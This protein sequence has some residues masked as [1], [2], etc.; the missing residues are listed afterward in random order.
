MTQQEYLEEIS[1]IDSTTGG[2]SP[3]QLPEE[4][5][6]DLVQEDPFL[7]EIRVITNIQ[8]EYQ[9]IALAVGSRNLIRGIENTAPTSGDL[10]NAKISYRSLI[11]KEAILPYNV[12]F[13]WIKQNLAGNRGEQQLNEEFKKSFK[14]DLVDLAFNGDRAATDANPYYK[15]ITIADGYFRL[16]SNDPDVNFFNRENNDT[17]WKNSVFPSMVQLLQK[18]IRFN[19]QDLFFL[20]SPEVAN[21]YTLQLAD[22]GTA[23]GDAILTQNPKIYFRGIE[24][25]AIPY[26]EKGKIILTPKK[27][28]CIGFGSDITLYKED[29]T[30]ARVRKYTLEAYIDFNYVQSSAI[31]YCV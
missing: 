29:D 25:K 4:F 12:S 30:R 2:L 7:N 15:F 27:N 10:K 31:V 20:V 26:V 18:V 19:P 22:R 28:L 24:I 23:L 17:D 6:T 8:K 9:L 14:N 3:V 13:R 16:V 11:P 21:E 5:I 1:K